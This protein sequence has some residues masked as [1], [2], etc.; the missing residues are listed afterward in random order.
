MFENDVKG[1]ATS[2]LLSHLLTVRCS[3]LLHIMRSYTDMFSLVALLI[4][5]LHVPTIEKV[6]YNVTVWSGCNGCHNGVMK[7]CN[8]C[9][10]D[11]VGILTNDVQKSL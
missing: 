8:S 7:L 9:V 10:V 6:P 11:H 3:K 5:L 1:L 4:Q 2:M